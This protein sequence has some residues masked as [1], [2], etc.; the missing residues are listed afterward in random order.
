M[1]PTELFSG[2]Q[3]THVSEQSNR[4]SYQSSGFDRHFVQR[5]LNAGN[6]GS[7]LPIED[8]ESGGAHRNSQRWSGSSIHLSE[9]G[10]GLPEWRDGDDETK[11][12]KSPT[13]VSTQLSVLQSNPMHL[14][15]SPPQ[16]ARQSLEMALSLPPA[17]ASRRLFIDDTSREYHYETLLQEPTDKGDF[18]NRWLL[19]KLCRSAMETQL[20]HS[21]SQSELPIQDVIRW[22]REALY[23]W[24]RDGAANLPIDHFEERE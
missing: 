19:H 17:V 10:D 14:L 24:P 23:F 16:T 8:Q 12:P 6:D 1:V 20:M 18:I 4:S 3:D 7:S 2:L 22:Q 13:L 9:K 15:E 5:N 21:I 11:A